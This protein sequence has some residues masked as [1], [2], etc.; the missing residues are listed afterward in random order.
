MLRQVPLWLRDLRA[1]PGGGTVQLTSRQAVTRVRQSHSICL[2]RNLQAQ[3]RTR[4]AFR[5]LSLP[6]RQGANM[7]ARQPGG[8]SARSIQQSCTV[9]SRCGLSL[10]ASAVAQIP[11]RLSTQRSCV[12]GPSKPAFASPARSL[13][14]RSPSSTPKKQRPRTEVRV[15]R[16]ILASRTFSKPL[17]SAMLSGGDSSRSRRSRATG[18]LGK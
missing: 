18:L 15:E 17:P 9:G 14:A 4:S 1:L 11:C 16:Y 10:A 6:V 2:K 8:V 7:R 13:G 3:R 12:H 5:S